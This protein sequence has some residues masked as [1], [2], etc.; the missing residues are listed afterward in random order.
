[1]IDRLEIIKWGF[2]EGLQK[3]GIIVFGK[4]DPSVLIG[5]GGNAKGILFYTPE[6]RIVQP[7]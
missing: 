3:R 2:M 4:D 5:E 7:Q 1:M 6:V